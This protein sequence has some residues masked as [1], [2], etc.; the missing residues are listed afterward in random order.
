MTKTS[1][2]SPTLARTET[3]AMANPGLAP[4]RNGNALSHSTATRRFVEA[5]GIRFAYRRFG[6]PIGTP[7]VLLQ[8]FMGNLDSY[9]PAITNAL[10]GAAR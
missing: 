6:N 8:H 2:P 10:A 9:D 7:I 3:E 4:T 1:N 5:G